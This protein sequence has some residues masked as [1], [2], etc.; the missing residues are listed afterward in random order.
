MAYNAQPTIKAA[1]NAHLCS[2]RTTPM[3][4]FGY[5]VEAYVA[6]MR[7]KAMV[8]YAVI[9]DGEWF[10][11]GKM[12]MF[13]YSDDNMTEEEWCAQVHKLYEE[14]P[15]DALLTLVDCHV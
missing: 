4:L 7:N 11:K 13:A 9:K 14:L 10:A 1:N 12:H 6:K 15:E 3:E 8:P 2:F 5:D